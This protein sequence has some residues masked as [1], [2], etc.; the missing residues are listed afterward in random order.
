[1][2]KTLAHVTGSRS[3]CSTR[4]TESERGGNAQRSKYDVQILE[5]ILVAFVTVALISHI[6]HDDSAGTDG[7]EDERSDEGEIELGFPLI[8]G[9]KT[10]LCQTI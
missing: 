3:R 7:G 1:M 9:V 4:K 2:C 8:T 6:H 5:G 10:R